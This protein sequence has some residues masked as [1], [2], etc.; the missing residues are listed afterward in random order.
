MTML[1]SQKDK[2]TISDV[3]NRLE[4]DD[5]VIKSLHSRFT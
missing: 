2:S 5:K 3:I 1:M 4:G